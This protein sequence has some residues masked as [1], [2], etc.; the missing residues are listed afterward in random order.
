MAS[1]ARTSTA[2]SEALRRARSCRAAPGRYFSPCTASSA[3][4]GGGS[5]PPSMLSSAARSSAGSTPCV[6]AVD[7]SLACHR[8]RQ[9][10]PARQP[11]LRFRDRRP[12]SATRA[13]RP[14][15]HDGAQF[16]DP[17]A[18]FLAM[19]RQHL[20]R[21]LRHLDV[22][23]DAQGHRSL[24]LAQFERLGWSAPCQRLRAGRSVGST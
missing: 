7:G 18:G 9:R 3:T 14:L 1:P 19:R 17:V 23:R 11:G 20:R 13:H 24:G 22:E 21:P 15:A 12:R 2:R 4:T 6:A 16:P 10:G 5:S 8:C